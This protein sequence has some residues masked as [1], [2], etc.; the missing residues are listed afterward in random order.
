MST[1]VIGNYGVGA[2][3]GVICKYN[4]IKELIWNAYSAVCSR[5]KR[6]DRRKKERNEKKILPC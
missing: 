3:Y 2:Y 1:I 5:E 4:I 6:E